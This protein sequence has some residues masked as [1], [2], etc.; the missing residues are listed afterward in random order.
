MG[1]GG[2]R[3]K[4]LHSRHCQYAFLTVDNENAE[5]SSLQ[6]LPS[7][8]HHRQLNCPVQ[9]RSLITSEYCST[10]MESGVW[11][12]CKEIDEHFE[13]ICI[14]ADTQ[15]HTVSLGNQLGHLVSQG[16]GKL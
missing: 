1:G 5:T 3:E 9:C 13:N 11:K 6:A 10:E 16:V 12:V 7:L 2:E 8:F 4:N 15:L 14:K